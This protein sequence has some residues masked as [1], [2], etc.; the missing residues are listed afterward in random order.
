M[1]FPPISSKGLLGNLELPILEGIIMQIFLPL[2]INNVD[3]KRESLFRRPRH[4][5]RRP[6][7]SPPLSSWPGAACYP[8]RHRPLRIG[9]A[10]EE[11]AAEEAEEGRRME[12][13]VAW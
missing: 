6:P 13:L 1:D 10:G 7:W 9:G 8:R 5:H 3:L 12:T 2:I 11:E 4:P